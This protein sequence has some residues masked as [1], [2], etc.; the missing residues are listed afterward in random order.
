MPLSLLQ[1]PWIQKSLAFGL[2]FGL[3][4]FW[5][6]SNIL[7]GFIISQSATDPQVQ[8]RRM[9]KTVLLLVGKMAFLFLTIGL[10]LWKRSVSPLA[11]LG[12]FTA[13][14]LVSIPLKLLK[15]GDEHA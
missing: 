4:N 8:K 9:V 5:F 13:S 3:I 12:G 6:L 14:L 11:F 2:I 10:L 15:K 1:D 7:S